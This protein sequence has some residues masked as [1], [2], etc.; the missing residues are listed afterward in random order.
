MKPRERACVRGNDVSP[1]PWRKVGTQELLSC[2]ALREG[3][4]QQRWYYEERYVWKCL[5]PRPLPD[6]LDK[7][8]P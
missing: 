3:H 4:S 6:S 7:G 2:V 8:L 1:L 5:A